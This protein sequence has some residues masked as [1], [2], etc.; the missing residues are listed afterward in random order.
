M[1]NAN[2]NPVNMPAPLPP[3]PPVPART[4]YNM[5][6]NA[7]V[8]V[9]NAG[10]TVRNR[11]LYPAGRWLRN[12]GLPRTRNA[13][14]AV[15]NRALYPAGRWLRNVGLPG[16]RNAGVAIRNRALY[17]AGRYIR[18][19]GAPAALNF[20]RRC[21]GAACR[22][23]AATAA[24]LGF[25]IGLNDG[26]AITARD[27]AVMESLPAA[28]GSPQFTAFKLAELENDLN[29]RINNY[30]L[31]NPDIGNEDGGLSVDDYK[32]LIPRYARDL[33][34]LYMMKLTS[35]GIDRSEIVSLSNNTA[36]GILMQ[37]HLLRTNEEG[38]H[39]VEYNRFTGAQ[40][41]PLL[42]E[43][44]DDDLSSGAFFENENENEN[45]NANGKENEGESKRMNGGKRRTRRNRR[46][47]RR[48]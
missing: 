31:D 45:E 34:T 43:L 26:L 3:A 46:S 5:L 14:V 28:Q 25:N 6:R 23:G 20:T 24:F 27:R 42:N 16:T 1:A 44:S 22:R 37:I 48:T 9:R 21:I 29:E 11:A 38:N 13:G 41:Q 32:S 47:T 35:M 18:N 2:P 39:Q 10:V 30:L 17:P 4:Y 15:R 19:V 8:A 7:G 36:T 12:V 40:L 33:K